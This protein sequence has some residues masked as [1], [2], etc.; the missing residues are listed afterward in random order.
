[1]LFERY[2]AGL[3][4]ADDEGDGLLRAKTEVVAPHPRETGIGDVPGICLPAGVFRDAKP[5]AAILVRRASLAV[6]DFV[7]QIH[8]HIARRHPP[9]A[10]ADVIFLRLEACEERVDVK[11]H[12]LTDIAARQD[13]RR[14]VRELYGRGRVALD[15]KDPTV[16][17][18][19]SR[20]AGDGFCGRVVTAPGRWPWCR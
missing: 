16:A 17:L 18:G 6:G 3:D 9:Y 5:L 11:A 15:L 4:L 8:A 20:L 19:I 7:D 10:D 1:M 14:A 12:A 13:A 2:R